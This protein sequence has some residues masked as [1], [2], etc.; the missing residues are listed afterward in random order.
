MFL[1]L[2]YIAYLDDAQLAAL[3]E[4]VVYEVGAREKEAS[5]I[6]KS[7]AAKGRHRRRAQHPG[8]GAGMER[9]PLLRHG[10][11]EEG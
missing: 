4:A 8:G 3:Y 6:G 9:A 11:K 1:C 2:D 10:R 5:R 7:E